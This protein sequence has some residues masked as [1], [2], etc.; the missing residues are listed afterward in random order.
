MSYP[1]DYWWK[2]KQG[3]IVKTVGIELTI[4]EKLKLARK[5]NILLR[6]QNGKAHTPL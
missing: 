1:K 2:N 3:K 4:E 6:V 5:N